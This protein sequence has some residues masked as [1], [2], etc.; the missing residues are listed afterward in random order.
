MRINR[1]RI[2]TEDTSSSLGG[3][4]NYWATKC[5]STRWGEPE[6]NIYPVHSSSVNNWTHNNYC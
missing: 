6:K 1:K 2:A 4:I 3:E 5:C